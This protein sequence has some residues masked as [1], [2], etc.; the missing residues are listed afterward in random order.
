MALDGLL[1]HQLQK[2]INTYLPAKLLKIQ[3]ISDAELLF[4][5]RTQKGNQKLM[6]SL[7]SV[8]NRI[9]FTQ[10]SYTTMETPGNF[11]MLLRKLIDGGIIRSCKQLG[12]DRILHMIVEARNEMGDIHSYHFYIELMGKYANLVLVGED[13]RII[14]ALKRIPP[15]E[16]NRRTIL[17]G[18][19][20]TLPAPHKDKQDPY[21]HGPFLKE[22]SLTKQFHGFS[23]LLSKEVQYRMHQGEEFDDI[24][25]KIAASDTLYI[26]DI[27]D[28]M[29][30][31]CIP[32]THLE[33]TYRTY[34]LMKGMDILFYHKEEKVRIKQQSGDL[35]KAVRKELHKNTSKLPKLE[36]SLEE[37]MDCEKY[38][39]YG[40]LL[41]AYMHTIEKTAQIT[42]PSFENEAMVTI[43][44][45]MRYDLKQNANRYYQ[46]YHKFKRAQNIL[47]EQ[48]CLCKQ[49]IEYFETLEIQLEQASMQD[50]MEIREELSKQNYIKPLKTRI[51]KKKKQELPHFETFQFD[52]ITIYVGKNNLQN[53]YVTWKL[54]RKQDTWLHVKDLHGSHVIITTDHPDEATLRNAA[55]LAAW[56]SQGRYSSSVPVNYCLVRQL[57]KIPGNKGSLV[58]LSNYK[59]IYID[60]DANYIQKLHDEHLAK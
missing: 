11:T 57:K 21:Q 50:A 32:L 19:Q 8:Y 42:L 14:D 59:T 26:S 48:I 3:Q 6:I 55:M 40:D 29:Y 25:Q 37:A 39:E 15:F 49:E 56:Y 1:L 51:R 5:L 36:A 27:K 24:M 33:G 54:A 2:E 35:F 58:S 43:P 20:F 31:H 38:R 60:P 22:E 52:D 45:D 53:D 23:P 47:S 16:N 28:Q 10:Q 34:P 18:A 7:H 4:T 13:N 41:F 9:H 44:I 46:K 17:P 12:L 30:F